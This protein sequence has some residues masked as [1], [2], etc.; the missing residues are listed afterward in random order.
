M[1]LWKPTSHLTEPDLGPS[2]SVSDLAFC[3]CALWE[4]TKE[5]P[6]TWVL[7]THVEDSDGIPAK[8]AQCWLLLVLGE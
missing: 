8:L 2:A 4:G 6:S 1:L 7:A 5:T 3:Q